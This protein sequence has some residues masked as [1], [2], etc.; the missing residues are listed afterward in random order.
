MPQVQETHLLYA[1]FSIAHR[2]LIDG[3][4]MALRR[5]QWACIGALPCRYPIDLSRYKSWVPGANKY[6]LMLFEYQS[7]MSASVSLGQSIDA[8]RRAADSIPPRRHSDALSLPCCRS[9]PTGLGH[10]P[11]LVAVRWRQRADRVGHCH[12]EQRPHDRDAK[13][14]QALRAG[15]P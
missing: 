1:L 3:Y 14:R 9:L 11:G 7:G 12:R 15:P 13:A 2:W 4:S 10:R 5:M 8:R 6:L